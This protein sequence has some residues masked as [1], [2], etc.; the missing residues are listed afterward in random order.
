MTNSTGIVCAIALTAFGLSLG[1]RAAESAPDASAK[2]ATTEAASDNGLAAWQEKEAK[3]IGALKEVIAAEAERQ[4]GDTTVDWNSVET[5]VQEILFRAGDTKDEGAWPVLQLG[6]IHKAQSG[7]RREEK[8]DKSQF[9]LGRELETLGALD[10]HIQKVESA[11]LA[12]EQAAADAPA[13][14]DGEPL[15]KFR[16]K[17]GAR[18][19]KARYKG[20]EPVN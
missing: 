2:A 1:A 7:L 9:A 14:Q 11:A 17:S 10:A 3:L 15:W 4:K 12:T 16:D 19:T 20:Q 13:A 5:K 8:H 6:W 18:T